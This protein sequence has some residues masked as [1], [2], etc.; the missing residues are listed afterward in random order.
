MRKLMI[1][2]TLSFSF[3]AASGVLNADGPPQC[4]PCPWV[5]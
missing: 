1:L 5:R 2:I 3:L 4:N